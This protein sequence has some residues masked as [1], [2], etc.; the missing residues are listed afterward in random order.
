MKKS[1][2]VIIALIYSFL[3]VSMLFAA[4]D[5]WTQKADFGGTARGGAVGFTI[6]TKGYI[7]TGYYNVGSKVYCKDFWEYDP[8]ANAWTQ[9][10]DFGGTARCTAA[11]FSI[12]SKG[13]IGMASGGIEG[14]LKDEFNGTLTP[15]ITAAGGVGSVKVVV[16]SL[17]YD[18]SKIIVDE[19]KKN[20]LN[21]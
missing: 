7:G 17:D 3:N 14:Y 2:I 10:A 18:T 15:W 1:I 9:K 21:S 5:T 13:Y 6:G 11:G 4:A 12:G 19:Y 20:S 16:S 8:T